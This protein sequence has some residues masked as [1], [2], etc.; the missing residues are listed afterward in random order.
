MALT[1]IRQKAIDRTDFLVIKPAGYSE[2][3]GNVTMH[4]EREKEWNSKIVKAPSTNLEDI[5][6]VTHFHG[7]PKSMTDLNLQRGSG[8][9]LGYRIYPLKAL[10]C[11]LI[12]Y[13]SAALKTSIS[14][15]QMACERKC[16]QIE[17]KMTSWV[18]FFTSAILSPFSCCPSAEMRHKIMS[19]PRLFSILTLSTQ[20]TATVHRPV[21]PTAL[22][23]QK[24][25]ARL[26]DCEAV[27][28]L[29]TL[30]RHRENQ[31]DWIRWAIR[32]VSCTL[33]RLHP[34]CY[35]FIIWWYI[36]IAYIVYYT[37]VWEKWNERWPKSS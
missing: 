33:Q 23:S 7:I 17:F 34:K 16:Y 6:C 14:H 32:Q 1:I 20:T 18:F 25:F 30:S 37:R 19:L 27:V 10:P 4:L 2:N 29:T 24:T 13:D 36:Y 3:T 12:A 22:F 28:L 15:H 35:L 11:L 8:N 21:H 9:P 26:H 5:I 31:N